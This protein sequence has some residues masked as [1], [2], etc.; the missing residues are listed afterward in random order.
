MD[1][2]GMPAYLFN[3]GF[4]FKSIKLLWKNDEEDREKEGNNS[5][6][7]KIIENNILDIKREKAIYGNSRSIE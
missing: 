4:T 2:D 7:F 5:L 3:E 1:F 6:C